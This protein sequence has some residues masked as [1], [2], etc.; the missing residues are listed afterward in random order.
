LYSLKLHS[1]QPEEILALNIGGQLFHTRRLNL[2]TRI[3]KYPGNST[4]PT[5]D[6]DFHEPHL[7][8]L[9]LTSSRAPTYD[10]TGALFIDKNPSFFSYVLDYL[11]N[12]AEPSFA[13]E[14]PRKEDLLKGIINEASYFSLNG[15]SKSAKALLNS[16]LVKNFR[17][18]I[19]NDE[20][21]RTMIEL[22]NLTD[23]LELVY[24]ASYHGF[25]AK[26]F[27]SKCDGISRT[28]TVVKSAK[29][30]VFGGY[31]E[32]AWS[33]NKSYGNDRNAYVFSLINKVGEKPFGCTLFWVEV[34]FISRRKGYPALM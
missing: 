25:S 8:Q 17:S 1:R 4:A 16:L 29:G 12:A 11:R 6:A 34:L 30:N 32:C 26:E 31:T 22:C 7:L 13:F 2:T 19:L 33:Q 20:E 27:H 10:A 14:L 23:R 15:L 5:T 21:K 9:L 18:S 24:R 3:S 28:L